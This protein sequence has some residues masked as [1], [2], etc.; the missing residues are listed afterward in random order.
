LL[1]F[2]YFLYNEKAFFRCFSWFL[3]LLFSQHAAKL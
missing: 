2:R 1:E 3:R